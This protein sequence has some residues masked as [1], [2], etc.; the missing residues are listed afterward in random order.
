MQ[1]QTDTSREET[2][3]ASKL[4]TEY[5]QGGNT[6]SYAAADREERQ[7]ARQLQTGYQG[8]KTGS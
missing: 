5:K 8:G 7:G 6:E 1:L 4:Q 2:Q 3:G